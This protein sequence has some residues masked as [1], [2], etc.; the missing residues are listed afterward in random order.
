MII[1]PQFKYK[2][3]ASLCQEKNESFC[4]MI[5]VSVIISEWKELRPQ[6]GPLMSLC[7]YYEQKRRN[8]IFPLL[9]FKPGLL[10]R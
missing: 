7:N 10:L 9:H 8:K 4:K 2:Q 3:P 5:R 6:V 1:E